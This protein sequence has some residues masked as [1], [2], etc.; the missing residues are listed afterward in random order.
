MLFS[1]SLQAQD[2][3]DEW[4]L[5]GRPECNMTDY[6]T[7]VLRAPK[8]KL[9]SQETAPLNARGVKHVPVVLVAFN[10]VQFSAAPT[11]E[12]VNAFY[13]LFCNGTNDGR[14]YTGHGSH[15]SIR[16]YFIAQSDSVFQPEFT[17]IGPVEL[18]SVVAYY[19]ENGG[20]RDTRVSYFYREAMYKAMKVFQDWDIFDNDGNGTIDM[21]FF[22]YAGLGES[23]TRGLF[24]NLLWPKESTTSITLNG[25][26]FATYAMTCECRPAT[27]NEERTEVLET[28][29]DGV[30]VFIHELSH[31]LGLPDFYDTKNVAFGMDIWSVMDYG[32]Y[33][34]DGYTPGN[35]T[36]YERDFMGWRPLKTLD[37]PCVLT[38]SCFADG[39]YGYKIQNDNAANEYYII[40]N[41]QPRGW[42]EEVGKRGHGLQVTHVDY[43]DSRWRNNRVNV[44][45]DHQRMTIVAANNL[46]RGTNT[47]GITR[48]EWYATL[49]GN[50]YPGDTYNYALTDD[51]DPAATVYAGGLLH[52]P[53]RNIT[54]NEDGTVTICFCTN[55][56]LDTPVLDDPENVMMDQFDARWAT[57][58]NATRYAYELY[59]GD[60]II[61]CDTIAEN[62]VHFDGL[63]PNSEFVLRV[64][65]MADFPEDYVNSE[66][67]DNLYVNTLSNYIEA[68]GESDKWV[69]VYSLN[70]TCISRCHADE[71]HRLSLHRGVY[72]VRY[73]N[74][75]ARKVLVN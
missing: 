44:D 6:E 21:V 8:R 40:E 62:T 20:A 67:S 12:E 56:Q 59:K 58:E 23:N 32:E 53:L 22:I 48:A 37:E 18:D 24:P 46:Y 47:S 9:G 66:W 16:D 31:A 28:R 26:T 11:N 30:G 4:L 39:G 13:H 33:G 15:G 49:A 75:A 55:G 38:L 19:G 34:G 68:V 2:V 64:M 52:K 54:E 65:A 73:A 29:T 42:D 63:L 14:L 60:L 69:D 50:L 41:R 1:V 5:D 43:D 71:L 27:W 74:G 72:I 25:R 7:N 10:D 51:S 35:Y 70:G 57:V 45:P 3:T 36:A 61:R 17:V